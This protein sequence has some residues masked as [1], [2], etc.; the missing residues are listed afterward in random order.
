MDICFTCHRYAPLVGGYET[1]VGLLAENLS[2]FFDIKVVTF[3]LVESPSQESWNGV[4][5][6]RVS[7]QLVFLR[8]PLSINF[9]RILGRLNFDVLHAHGAVPLISDASILYAKSRKKKTV[10]THHFDGNVQDSKKLNRLADFYNRTL[11]RLCVDLSDA[12]VTTSKSYA[13]TSPVIRPHL[14]KVTV[15]PCS[16][17]TNFFKPQPESKVERFKETL[18]LADEKVVLFVG[19]IVP[20]KGLEFL[21]RA[22]QRLEK[23]ANGGFHLLMIGKGEGRRITDGSSYFDKIRRLVEKSGIKSKVH[24][25]G[26]VSKEELPTYYS[27]AD[28]VVLPSTMR[29]EAFGTVLLEALA[30]GTPVVASDLPGVMDVLKGKDHVGCYVPLGE[31]DLLAEALAKTAYEKTHASESCRQFAIDN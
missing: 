10:Y 15:I 14:H 21:V 4:E 6:H 25:L 23:D 5:V 3:K 29:G 19:R 26:W 31:S 2:R 20:Y 24:F 1:Q 13:E 30:C 18:R 16:V 8:I 22:F 28:V 7:P 17:D 27:L 9:L 11:G 12:V